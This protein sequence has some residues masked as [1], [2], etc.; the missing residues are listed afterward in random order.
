MI[1]FEST[2]YSKKKVKMIVS[3]EKTWMHREHISLYDLKQNKIHLVF[4][5]NVE[6]A[7]ACLKFNMEVK[8]YGS[9]N[10][11]AKPRS[12]LSQMKT[13]KRKWKRLYCKLAFS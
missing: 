13:L 10:E 4:K 11:K 7:Y 8:I 12:N 2:S 5:S 1:S 9:L 6:I 3:L